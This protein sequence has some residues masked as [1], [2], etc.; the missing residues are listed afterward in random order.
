MPVQQ[1]RVLVHMEA[2]IVWQDSN[3]YR[4]WARPSL[5]AFILKELN[6]AECEGLA[7]KTSAC[8]TTHDRGS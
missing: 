5:R 6:A 2:I 1:M 3:G 4:Q 8:T 7:C